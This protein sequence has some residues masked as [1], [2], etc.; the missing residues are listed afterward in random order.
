MKHKDR[1][2]DTYR[3]VQIEVCR[4]SDFEGKPIWNFYLHLS[5]E[6]IEDPGL[7]EESWLPIKSFEVLGFSGTT[8]D[9]MNAWFSNLDFHHGITYFQKRLLDNTRDDKER[10]AIQIGCD[11]NHLWDQGKTYTAESV[12]QDARN[13]VDSLH[14]YLKERDTHYLIHANCCGRLIQEDEGHMTGDSFYPNS[15]TCGY[16]R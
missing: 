3:G 15:C 6:Q 5:L 2:S 13:C 4:W 9:Y 10:R 16:A 8:Y 12:M 14:A 7:R 1:W 11:Y